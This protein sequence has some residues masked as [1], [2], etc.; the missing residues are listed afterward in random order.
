MISFLNKIWDYIVSFLKWMFSDLKT[1]L[2]VIFGILIVFLYFNLRLVKNDYENVIIEKN[3]S[4]SVYENK[5]G[6]L[7]KEID[8]YI[9]DISHL[10]QSNSELYQE[11]KNL[12]DNPIVVT[13]IETVI[14]IEEKVVKDTVHV[15]S[16]EL[17]HY[18]VNH[19]YVDDYIDLNMSTDFF[20]NDLSA[21]TTLDY[22]NMPVNI[23]LDLIESKKGQLSFIAKSDNPYMEINNINGVVLSP[24]DS[25]AIKKRYDK[26]WCI[27]GGIGGS[28]TVIDNNVKFVPALQLTFGY[29][30]FSF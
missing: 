18:L 15:V 14:Q 27:V 2:L 1:F 21:Y 17:G 25:K 7:Y 22:I 23:S 26:R 28:L 13:K 16:K 8:T 4:I 12:K 3:D 20:L 9:T 5:V 19:S 29:K 30:F 11:V 6:E 10:K 24:E